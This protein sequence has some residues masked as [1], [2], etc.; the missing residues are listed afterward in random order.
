MAE[1]GCSDEIS[2]LLGRI[3]VDTDAMRTWPAAYYNT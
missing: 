2:G 1:A 3:L